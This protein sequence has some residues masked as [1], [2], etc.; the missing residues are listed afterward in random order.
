MD[1]TGHTAGHLWKLAADAL[2]RAQGNIKY[3]LQS[4]ASQPSLV[5]PSQ[6]AECR[7]LGRVVLQN[8]VAL[9]VLL[10]AGDGKV[11]ELKAAYDFSHHSRY[12]ALV[13]KGGAAAS[14][15]K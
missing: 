3:M 1:V 2:A 13:L 10:R 11:S 8:S 6:L 7:A 5:L 12:P 9:N 4:A 14:T 15:T